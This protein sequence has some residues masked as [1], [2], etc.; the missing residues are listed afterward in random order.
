M[1]LLHTNAVCAGL[2][3]PIY[4]CQH[5]ATRVRLEHPNSHTSRKGPK[6]T[7]KWQQHTNGKTK[8][9]FQT[10]FAMLL[11]GPLVT[12]LANTT[13]P[14]VPSGYSPTD[15]P[16]TKADSQQPLAPCTVWWYHTTHVHPHAIRTP[17]TCIIRPASKQIYSP[18]ACQPS[19]WPQK[20]PTVSYLAADAM[21]SE[22]GQHGLLV[23]HLGTAGRWASSSGTSA[24]LATK[25]T[26]EAV[27]CR[28]KKQTHNTAVQLDQW[29]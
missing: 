25:I 22:H 12:S 4:P 29:H 6:N 9:K 19:A 3:T 24:R 2:S 13:L 18:A 8:S 17:K 7:H 16:H 27:R 10:Q 28:I 1:L 15:A 14:V 20:E 5:P 26:Q 11:Q 23:L 21:P